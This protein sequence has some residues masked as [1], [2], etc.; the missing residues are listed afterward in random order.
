MVNIIEVIDIPSVLEVLPIALEIEQET[1][2][3]VM[4]YSMPVPVGSFIDDYILL[5]NELLTQGRMLIVVD[6][7][8][9]QLLPEHVAKADPLIQNLNFSQ[10]SQYST[11]IHG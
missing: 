2:L 10:H 3:L 11:H 9:D 1:F 5:I 8:L 4:V 7:N 6:F